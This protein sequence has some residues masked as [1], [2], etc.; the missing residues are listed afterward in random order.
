MSK[1]SNLTVGDAEI[2]LRAYQIWE[3][4]GKPVGKDF[5]HWLRAKA[6][7]ASVVEAAPAAKAPATPAPAKKAAAKKPAG[8]KPAAKK[9]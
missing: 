8:R 2:S 9:A 1:S 4:E 3:A 5:E 6:E 7:L